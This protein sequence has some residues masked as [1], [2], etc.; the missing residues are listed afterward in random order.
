MK[1]RLPFV[2]IALLGVSMVCWRAEGQVRPL[3]RQAPSGLLEERG[4]A[5]STGVN[6][7][8]QLKVAR[9]AFERSDYSVAKVEVGR[10][11][12]TFETSGD[13]PIGLAAAKDL[14]GLIY[15]K[16]GIPAQ[17][18]P[19]HEKA[20]EVF[21][22]WGAPQMASLLDAKN[23]KA[24]AHYLLGQYREAAGL[25]EEV[26][27]TA[28]NPIIRARAYNNLG[29]VYQ[30]IGDIK[31]AR[32]SFAEARTAVGD[33]DRG[34]RAEVLNNIARLEAAEGNLLDAENSLREAEVL[35]RGGDP[36]LV[37][38]LL[39]SWGEILLIANRPADALE[40]LKEASALEANRSPV[41]KGG[42]QI[43][44]GRA[45]AALGRPDE[46]LA[47]L[48]EAIQL[49]ASE[50][51]QSLE[52]KALEVRGDVYSGLP[53]PK[54]D[55]A[56]EDHR[57]A[58]RL[59]ERRARL[60]G[61]T[62]EEFRRA[63]V[64]QYEK[65]A[66]HLLERRKPG[67]VEEAL[68]YL[69][70]KELLPVYRAM[71][72]V[73]PDLRDKALQK[74]LGETR[75]LLTKEE[76]LAFHLQL[77][78]SKADPD[79]A[80]ID[81]I[82]RSL[83]EVRK[84]TT[85]A[86]SELSQRYGPEFSGYVQ[87]P[88]AMYQDFKSRLPEGTIL[89]A[90][91]PLS[92]G[93]RIFL[94][95]RNKVE[96]RQNLDA[97]A[98]RSEL[99]DKIKAYREQVARQGSL[100]TAQFVQVPWRDKQWDGLRALSS[101][102]YKIL[103]D[104]IASELKEAK[105][106]IFVLSGR[107]HYLPIHAL[108]PIDPGTGDIR[109]LIEEKSVSYLT[110]ATLLKAAGEP[111]KPRIRTLV[112]LGIRTFDPPLDPLPKAEKEVEDLGKIFGASA[113]VLRGASATRSALLG[114]L[115]PQAAAT[116]GISTNRKGAVT[117][118]PNVGFVHLSTHG[119][120]DPVSPANSWL[121][122]DGSNRLLASEIPGKLDLRNVSL[123]TLSACQT[124]LGP[125]N[126]GP[127]VASFAAYFAQAGAPSGAR[128]IVVSLW[129]VDDLASHDLMVKLYEKLLAKGSISKVRAMQQ[130]QAHLAGKPETR[131]PYF[132]APFVL[133]GDWR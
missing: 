85:T 130:A 103:L 102:L 72:T 74:A 9:E 99:D 42:I 58:V 129:S 95:S 64:G 73:K 61:E 10:V 54:L 83:D 29:L 41:I 91:F 57:K 43:N 124:G 35:A 14:L 110:D 131:H 132:W 87:I 55:E 128:S 49:A 115:G 81:V 96:F 12:F 93:L 22:Y 68:E 60:S 63:T 11:I 45:L 117:Q 120:V 88:P 39:D 50:D 47:A 32:A 28:Q 48:G 76:T 24:V 79:R 30:E 114:R 119:T 98:K 80:R 7:L 66:R 75:E 53:T 46:A 108:G 59:A 16:E 116:S 38:N 56:I 33:K 100:A 109:F 5:L 121:A 77:E 25:Y 69:G 67:D 65:L 6:P 94:V 107:L 127:A 106:V 40:K 62:E 97:N 101:E 90:Y 86:I 13:N 78:Q 44:R 27:Q 20:I 34:V 113:T 112:A 3:E 122:L 4:P 123:V 105:H 18:L 17:A 26:V 21:R 111:S 133:I 84:Q 31:K 82:R 125:E 1:L 52:R 89:V 92:D 126:P 36:A 23:N 2:L 37:A 104:R 8:E 71:V 15:Q 19:L 51:L 70:R 118:P